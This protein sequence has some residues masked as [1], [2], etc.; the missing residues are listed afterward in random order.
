MLKYG[1]GWVVS[2]VDV[3][4]TVVVGLRLGLQRPRASLVQT[5]NLDLKTPFCL[6]PGICSGCEVEYGVVKQMSDVRSG[7]HL[8]WL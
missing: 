7:F 3:D 4:D 6:I 1:F 2:P 8:Q 5:I